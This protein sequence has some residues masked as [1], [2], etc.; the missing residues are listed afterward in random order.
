MKIS[1]RIIITGYYVTSCDQPT[2]SATRK[3]YFKLHT[4][5]N[6]KK[7]CYNMVLLNF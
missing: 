7:R 5:G 1:V 2:N 4:G 3:N 6:G